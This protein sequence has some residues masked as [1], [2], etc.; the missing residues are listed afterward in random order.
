MDNSFIQQA[1]QAEQNLNS[2]SSGDFLSQLK[3]VE[4]EMFG[5][6]PVAPLA[7]PSIQDQVA[8]MPNSEKLSGFEQ[9]V[10]KKLPG[11]SD[12]KIGQALSSFA[13]SP[14]GKVLEK[15]DI[16]AEGLERTL[17]LA[18][19]LRDWKAGDEF[20]LKEA[21]DASTLTYDVSKLP[22]FQK[23]A[24]GNITGVSIDN[25]MP[26]AYAL[27]DARKLLQEGKSIDE[28]RENLYANLGALALRSQLQDTLG[29]IALDP[30]NF[31]LGAIKPVQKLHAIRNLAVTGKIDPS[32]IKVMQAEAR[33]AGNLEDAARFGQAL[34][35]AE[36][37]GK[38]L[39]RFEKF[40]IMITGGTPYTQNVGDMS[41]AQQ[42]LQKLNPFALTPQAKA[43]ELLDVVAANVGEYLVRPNFNKDP[44]VFL[45]MISRA[46]KGGIGEQWGHVAATIQGRTVQG[47]L[48]NADGAVKA[49][50]HEW[51]LY[52]NQRAMIQ[53]VMSIMPDMT[54]RGVWKMAKE[55]PAELFKRVM[56]AAEGAGDTAFV[57]GVRAGQI[58]PQMFEEIGKIAKGTPL[59]REEFYAKALVTIQDVAARQAVLQF[60]IKEKGLM[61]KWADALKA[62]ETIP[63]IR[64]NPANAFRNM[65]NND[66]TLMAR[67]VFGTMPASAIDDFWKGKYIPEHFKRGFSLGAEDLESGI[68]HVDDFLVGNPAKTIVDALEG[69]SQSLAQKLKSKAQNL[70]LGPADVI[71]RASAKAE[72]A[73][74]KR[75]S[76]VGW[77]E[78]HNKYWNA[79]TGFTSA[80]KYLPSS[81][82][83]EIEAV[84]P[85]LIQRLDKLAQESGADPEKLAKL[86]QT[87]GGTT[88]V[89]VL[90]DVSA[91]LGYNLNDTLGPEVLARFTDE[92][93]DA[94]KNG[95]VNEL[96]AGVRSTMEK[97]VDD[98]FD[99]HLENLPGIIK[100]QVQAGGPQQYH[101]I[102]GKATD[103]FWAG[104]TEHALRMSRVNEALDGAKS[105][106]DYERVSAI[107]EK[108]FTDT[109]N[110]FNRVWK[111]FDAYQEGLSDGAKAAGIKYPGEV[112]SSFQGM[113]DGWKELFDTRNKEYKAFFESKKSGKE[114]TKTLEQIQSKIDDMYAKMVSKE[115]ELFQRIDDM[116]A[117][118]M[119][120]TEAAMYRNFRDR[121]SALRIQDRTET[122]KF[123]QKVRDL[124]GEEQQA[125]WA[126]YWQTRVSRLEQIRKLEYR[127]SAAMQGSPEAVAMFMKPEMTGDPKNI[128][129]LAGQFGIS[130]ATEAGARNNR[131]ILNTVNKYLDDGVEKFK[132]VEDIPMDVAAR[133]FEKRLAKQV[134]DVTTAQTKSFIPDAE[135][136][137]KD[138]MPIETAI[139]EL[140]YGRGYA[141]LDEVVESAK[142]IGGVKHRTLPELP[143]TAQKHIQSW[144][145]NIEDESSSFRAAGVQYA[146]FRR[147]SALLNYNRRTNFDNW[148][149]HMAPFAFWTTHSV[150]NWALYS[151]DRPAMMTSYFRTREFFETAGLTDQN[152]PT[153]LKGQIRIN[154]PFM[155][156]WMGDQFIDPTRIALPFDAWMQPWEQAQS[157]KF[158][159]EGKA[160]RTLE[161][162]LEAGHITE[163]E[164]TKALT[165]NSGDAWEQAMAA[166]K[167][168]G[169]QYDAM[170][171]VSMTM[172]PH[173]PLMW[174]YNAATGNKQDIGPFTPLSRTVKN[175]ATMMGVDDWSNS[176]YNIEG[177]LRKMAG[178]PAFD[179]WDDY[180]VGRMI[181]NLA[182][183]GN[184]SIDE[185]KNAME[186]AALVESGKMTSEEAVKTN[187][188]YKEA[189]KRANQEYAGGW[190]GTLLGVIGIPVKSFPTGEARQRELADKFSDAYVK[191]DQGD[192]QALTDFFDEYPE[193]ES[194]LALFKKPEER[195]K[196]FMVDNMW[197][198]WNELPAVTQNEIKEQLGDN[199]NNY[200][201]TKETRSYETI[202]PEQLQ[203]WL[204][205]IGGK[206]VGRL[207]TTEEIMLELNQL[208][209]TEPE[210]AWRVETFYDGRKDFGN[211]Y[212]LQNK[213]YELPTAKRGEFLQQ[214][215][216][217]KSYW[218]FRQQWMSTNPDLVKFLTDDPKQLAKYESKRR[219]PQVAVPTAQEIRA[220][221]SQ[222]SIELLAEWNAGNEIPRE[223]RQYLNE[224]AR[225]YNIDPRTLM[226][227][228]S[229][230]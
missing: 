170:D 93:P 190:A 48:S 210:T 8:A 18:A 176:P 43:S 132:R 193:Y 78:F 152:V 80:Q 81:V 137:F 117:D 53:R 33:L 41:K 227:I 17:G 180:R 226:G 148:V 230:P 147:D 174:A 79:K 94:I 131:R 141:A 26:G 188:L 83:D 99:A 95:R 112:K 162:M 224:I 106:K 130:S 37:N 228:L 220:N 57:N 21:W 206:Q 62:W 55:N 128:F 211:W 111:K 163:Q 50:G 31:I 88:A 89:E 209:L 135:M 221:F 75:A 151:L 160:K 64:A 212:E 3:N 91:R 65:V 189:T 144:M 177:R 98:M 223:L 84:E 34:V 178:L 29:H 16:L 201:L 195:L 22:R 121:S 119:P 2:A 61:T 194:R 101:R 172:S 52:E 184:Y 59:F 197:A 143:E 70:S 183:D 199:F 153:R 87:E 200:F 19:Q 46:A 92:L 205:L 157:S 23:D 173:A 113:K 45:D 73:A 179:K 105:A 32:I 25:D 76:T 63:F 175:F 115:D 56:M 71:S 42:F 225:T 218:N 122:Q 185:M 134:E 192:F 6:P 24:N 114:Y 49:L 222:P 154:L 103:E 126:E 186:V 161:Q 138:P 155:P 102:F 133:S 104:N 216:A 202:K 44:E 82:I 15:L 219:E 100:A 203:V 40:A 109:E 7:L 181:S 68:T 20:R 198:R 13:A 146:S 116:M 66:I 167:E 85:G 35:D 136:I 169:E 58:T 28:V 165:T 108:V 191:Y 182:A 27:T 158:S 214:N 159:I 38:A 86:L 229:Q 14:A 168:G 124:T 140:N 77:M 9:W 96:V 107:W 207:S 60:G 118:S 54:E 5:E 156:D 74:S 97:H 36:K 51:K 196:S 11:V 120:K 171:F 72:S 12:S 10:Y 213:Y 4:R 166:A 208:K 127:G 47:I 69:K 30:L 125:A 110:H 217:L 164:Y 149:G 187:A 142:R 39:T 90:E 129:E 150:F 204:K 139:S 145:R 215:P 1:K 67:G 123:F